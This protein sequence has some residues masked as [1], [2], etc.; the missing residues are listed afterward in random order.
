M[1][2]TE[3]DVAQSM[4]LLHRILDPTADEHHHG[5]VDDLLTAV[6]LAEELLAAFPHID[7]LCADARFH[8][9][10]AC[11]ELFWL[12]EDSSHLDRELEH[13]RAGVRTGQRDLVE[14]LVDALVTRHRL[15]ER[16]RM[17]DIDEAIGLQ[18]EQ[19]TSVDA[20]SVPAERARLG[21]LIAERF[22]T[23]AP[24]DPEDLPNLDEAIDILSGAHDTTPRDDPD[25]PAIVGALGHLHVMSHLTPR[26]TPGAPSADDLGRGIDLLRSVAD[27]DDDAADRLAFAL[28]LRYSEEKRPED[29]DAAIDLF[30]RLSVDDPGYF[31]AC[32]A[33]LGTLYVAR[34]EEDQDHAVFERAV[35]CLSRAI[36]QQRPGTEYLNIC[37][38]E[39][40]VRR[41]DRVPTDEFARL[42]TLCTEMS[43]R[44]DADRFWSDMALGIDAET[45]S[46][47]GSGQ[48]VAACVARFTD[49]VVGQRHDRQ[50][51]A[52]LAAILA[53]LIAQ[54]HGCG[55]PAGWSPFTLL[56]VGSARTDDLV[57]WLRLHHDAIPASSP[58][59]PMFVIGLA[60]LSNQ[61]PD[62][63]EALASLPP[64]HPMTP[65][66][67]YVLGSAY[68]A[69]T[70]SPDRMRRSI[71]RLTD[72]VTRFAPDHAHRA[73][74]VGELGSAFILGYTSAA[75]DASHVSRADT[76]LTEALASPDLESEVRAM[77][78]ATLGLVR[79]ISWMLDPNSCALGSE[80]ALH[81]QAMALLASNPPM[82]AMI[83]ANLG[84]MLLTRSV[85]T[86]NLDDVAEAE[87]HL[88]AVAQLVRETAD[89]RLLPLE[90]I[91]E[92][93]RVARLLR[94]TSDDDIRAEDAAELDEMILA[95][96]AKPVPDFADEGILNWA[97]LA[98]ARLNGDA[99]EGLAVLEQVGTSVRDVPEHTPFRNTIV[100]MQNFQ[101]G[102]DAVLRGDIVQLRDHVAE[103]VKR[104]ESP[105]V[106]DEEK[107]RLFYMAGSL[108]RTAHTKTGDTAYL[109]NAVAYLERS[110]RTAKKTIEPYTMF[111]AEQLT[112]VY[113]RRD[114]PGD[115]DEAIRWGFVALHEH[116]RQVLLHEQLAHGTTKAST[117][118]EHAHALT[119][120]CAA[121]GRPEQAV[122]AIEGGRALAMYAATSADLVAA[123]LRELGHDD[124][125][126][127]WEHSQRDRPARAD[128]IEMPSDLRY[129]VL[130]LLSG[131]DA[132]QRLLSSPS[133]ADIALALRETGG[134]ALVY[135][136]P[137]AADEPGQALVIDTDGEV[138]VLP[139]P[140]LTTEEGG[141]VERYLT[142]HRRA[143]TTE[144]EEQRQAVGRWRAE[145]GELL[146][147]AWPAVV[148]PVL[149]ELER[150]TTGR[151]PRLV[152]VP[153]GPLGVVP[154]QAA[155]TDVGGRPRFAVE[156]AVFSYAAS[157][158]QLCDTAARPPRDHEEAVAVVADPEEDL[159]GATKEMRYLHRFLYPEASY[160]GLVPAEIT[161]DGEGSPDDVL[162]LL[163]RAGEA[164]TSL[165]HLSCHAWTG[166]TPAES[167]LRLAD[168]EQL[169]VAEILRHG[170]G[171]PRNARGG[172]VV[173]SACGSDLADRDHDEALTVASAFLAGGAATVVG[174][175]WQVADLPAA[176][177]M[178][179]F[180]RY[181]TVDRL[182]AA[183]ALRAAQLWA[184]DRD[185]A[186][187]DDIASV[188]GHLAEIPLT[189][190]AAFSHQ[191]R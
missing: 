106:V 114:K 9:S 87:S 190:W 177:L 118:A 181:L 112:D 6:R 82:K 32:A 56:A 126:L 133:P 98:R 176:L 123:V 154:W 149:S 52:T 186:L 18:R 22:R 187:P 137:A 143:T 16:G 41:W 75:I 142:A 170:R 175:R 169:T 119:H 19:V 128:H 115:A 92:M 49:V 90:A 104:A 72:A 35:A 28:D 134:D 47:D 88:R 151:T 67:S 178:C 46:T 188:F 20:D 17:T 27:A 14:L 157:A 173:L 146:W 73:E 33:D 93:L 91:E 148:D 79:G 161:E 102:A 189:T 167:F 38:V 94:M 37:L 97:R 141:P 36:R 101:V 89:E 99:I 172:L 62:L 66:V 74:C 129:R 184:L 54:S 164:G 168:G 44:D 163:P 160:Y 183:E 110:H 4:S 15:G 136:V 61:A 132:E 139:L 65:Y 140:Q 23:S 107:A 105:G 1:T 63:E 95:L 165:L 7:E 108:W 191:G 77:L 147:W 138:H 171:L 125:A 30:E 124:T 80:V 34:L 166:P 58:E 51:M 76:L 31:D 42:H 25:F 48:A 185:S 127:E 71:E 40:Y 10:W 174:T 70:T 50:D 159:F 57:A 29:R 84:N 156:R 116:A 145:L 117:V 55:T 150:G 69:D 111:A 64:D 78:L 21:L 152:L 158:R 182:P 68:K 39:A 60:L 83:R 179:L 144:D 109:D 81:E 122:A 59:H 2:Q 121:A 155:R 113:W 85:I 120:R 180:H 153:C 100:S 12:T 26:I 8:A 96:E 3:P 131:T 103:I 130:D 53:V 135:L 5:R 13:L 162:A 43:S 86:R 11:D 24:G 45:A